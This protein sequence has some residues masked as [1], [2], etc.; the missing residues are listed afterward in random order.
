VLGY[1]RAEYLGDVPTYTL[2]AY[3]AWTKAGTVTR[4]LKVAKGGMRPREDISKTGLLEAMA[5]IAS[6]FILEKTELAKAVDVLVPIAPSPEKLVK[7]EGLAPND[8][9][10]MRLSQ[11]LA[12]PVWKAVTRA[13]GRPTREASEDELSKQ[14]SVP[15]PFGRRLKGLTILLVEDIWTLGRTIPICAKKLREFEPEQIFAI[16]LAHSAH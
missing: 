8:I 1:P 12:L 2:S 7:R 14:F 15:V 16:A 4:A 13:T 5:E 10:A 6:D 11:R 9:V 3:H